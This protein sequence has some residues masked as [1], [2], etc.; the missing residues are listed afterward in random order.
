[1]GGDHSVTFPIVEALAGLHGPL[2]LLFFD[3]HDEPLAGVGWGPVVRF[4]SQAAL[5][6]HLIGIEQRRQHS[7]LK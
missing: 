5:L 2:N 1:M 4:V 6:S 7:D 3:A